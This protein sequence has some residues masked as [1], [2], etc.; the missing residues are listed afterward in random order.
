MPNAKADKIVHTFGTQNS[1][2]QKRK[3]PKYKIDY[4]YRL[5]FLLLLYLCEIYQVPT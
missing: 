3:I 2:E 5:L 4:Y 1:T